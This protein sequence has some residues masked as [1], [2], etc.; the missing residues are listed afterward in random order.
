VPWLF[1]RAPGTT[2]PADPPEPPSARRSF[3]LVDLGVVPAGELGDA[4]LTRALTLV[5]AAT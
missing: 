1:L 5:L 2:F 4:A 3:T